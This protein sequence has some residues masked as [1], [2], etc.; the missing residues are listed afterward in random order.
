M[1]SALVVLGFR[2][3]DK[4]QHHGRDRDQECGESGEIEAVVGG[5]RAKQSVEPR[6]RKKRRH[7]DEGLVDHEDRQNECEDEDVGEKPGPEKQ[8]R[9]EQEPKIAP[10]KLRLS[11][12]G[13]GAGHDAG[14][15]VED[16]E[17]EKMLVLLREYEIRQCDQDD[18]RHQ[19][20]QTVN[21]R[22]NDKV[23]DAEF[24]GK[25]RRPLMQGIGCVA[26]RLPEEKPLAGRETQEME[27]SVGVKATQRVSAVGGS[28][29]AEQQRKQ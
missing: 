28:D 3:Q 24:H 17:D 26:W 29:G 5:L 19:H 12:C 22:Q 14:E 27:G 9:K 23:V 6:Q 2:H 7:Q 4:G 16:R 20:R 21:T 25:E 8:D 1:R 11:D 15:I 10:G 18:R 13:E